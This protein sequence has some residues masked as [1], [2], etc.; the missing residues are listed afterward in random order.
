M[1]LMATGIAAGTYRFQREGAEREFFITWTIVMLLLPAT[2]ILGLIDLRL[3][4]KLR[5]ELRQRNKP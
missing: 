4:I 5:E 1:L 3:T 2:V